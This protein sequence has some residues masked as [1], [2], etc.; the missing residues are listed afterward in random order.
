ML[1]N[2]SVKYARPSGGVVEVIEWGVEAPSKSAAK[3]LVKKMIEDNPNRKVSEWVNSSVEEAKPAFAGWGLPR[4]IQAGDTIT[5]PMKPITGALEYT[6]DPE[7]VK[8]RGIVMYRRDVEEAMG[9]KIAPKP[10]KVTV[11]YYSLYPNDFCYRAGQPVRSS[12]HGL[13][14]LV[15]V[16]VTRHD[17][18]IVNKEIV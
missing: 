16:K 6:G 14:Q 9:R 4:D 15:Q 8:V 17:G 13:D 3:R 12:Q 18:R 7:V 11:D 5:V 10:P 2:V 1:Y